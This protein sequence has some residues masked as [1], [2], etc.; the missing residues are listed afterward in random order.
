MN[1]VNYDPWNTLH[2]MRNEINSLF[3]L[4]GNGEFAG[5]AAELSQGTWLPA[6]DIRED[7]NAYRISADLPGI[8]PKDVEVTMENNVLTIRGERNKE[9]IDPQDYR[10]VERQYGVFV[11]RFTLPSDADP[12]QITAEGKHGTLEIVVAKNEKAK[13]K[14]ITVKN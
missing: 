2:K 7:E 1:L 12:D 8:N 14:R 10:R 11:R 5:Q 4:D 6:V 13:P 9:K 3:S